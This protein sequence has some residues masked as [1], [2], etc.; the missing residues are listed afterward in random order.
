MDYRNTNNIDIYL[1][2]L[3]DCKRQ[4][5]PKRNYK[6][7]ISVRL[8]LPRGVFE[9]MLIIKKKVALKLKLGWNYTTI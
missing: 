5:P 6:V 7:L 9:K 3:L 8:I 4:G 1:Q 2:I